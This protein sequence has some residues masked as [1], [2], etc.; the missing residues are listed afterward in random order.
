M[1]F[2]GWNVVSSR[3]IT[4]NSRVPILGFIYGHP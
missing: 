2:V 4:P 1:N 3:T